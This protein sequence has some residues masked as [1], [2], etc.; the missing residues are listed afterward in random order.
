MIPSSFRKNRGVVGIPRVHT[1]IMAL[2]LLS[3]SAAALV[4]QNPA[5]AGGVSA[6]AGGVPTG[7]TGGSQISLPPVQNS[8]QTAPGVTASNAAADAVLYPGEDFRLGSGDL[9][10]VRLFLVQDYTA[11]VRLDENGNVQLPLIGSVPL[12]GLSVRQAQALIADRLRQ[13]EFFR[14]PD[15]IIQVLQTVNGTAEVPVTQ[16]RSL[17]DVLLYAGGL[18]AAAS[19]TIKIVR[20]G[21]KDPI[22]V[23]LGT[24]L[25]SSSE[26]DMPILPH[27]IIQITRASLVY[28][29]GAFQR[30]GAFPLDQATPLTLMQCAALSGGINFEAK[31]ADLRIIRTYGNDRKFVKVDIKRI[32]E[33]KDPDPVLQANDIVYLPPSNLKAATKNLGVGGVLGLLGLVLSLRNY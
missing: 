6:G 9:I 15:V 10:S 31:Y 14:R 24:D 21:Q 11:T 8:M 30:Q 27:D 18:P 1:R 28:V 4:A 5:P 22:V 33:G 12:A 13:G 23:N 29:L 20:R 26:A 32:R 17:R 2:L 19:H 25:A 16:Q 7:Q 3:A